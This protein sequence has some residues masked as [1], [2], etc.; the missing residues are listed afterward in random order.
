[1]VLI[2]KTVIANTILYYRELADKEVQNDW[3]IALKMDLKLMLYFMNRHHPMQNRIC[4]LIRNSRHD[5]GIA[6]RIEL[7]KRLSKHGWLLYYYIVERFS[8]RDTVK[9]FKQLI[10]AQHHQM[11]LDEFVGVFI[12]FFFMLS[13]CTFVFIVEIVYFT[14]IHLKNNR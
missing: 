2:T 4:R 10:N 12:L 11:T 1:M 13:I 14:L 8:D 6:E 5:Y 3:L 7:S 9:I